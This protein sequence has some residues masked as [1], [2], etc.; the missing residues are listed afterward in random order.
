MQVDRPTA[1]ERARVEPLLVGDALRV[2]AECLEDPAEETEEEKRS[3]GVVSNLLESLNI[4]CPT[5][6]QPVDPRPDG[7]IAIR[8]GPP[9]ARAPRSIR[10]S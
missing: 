4:T 9:D 3:R 2:Y 7:C 5:C 8:K 6:K 1:F 10:E